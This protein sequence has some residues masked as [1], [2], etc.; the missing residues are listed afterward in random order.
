M[1]NPAYDDA[2]NDPDAKNHQAADSDA[3]GQ[4]AAS[5]AAISTYSTQDCI[6]S[7]AS[8]QCITQTVRRGA[9]RNSSTSIKASDDETRTTTADEL[10]GD[11][12]SRTA[13]IALAADPAAL[14][15]PLTTW[16][17]RAL[18]LLLPLYALLLALF[19]IRRRKRFYFVDHLVFSLSIHTFTFVASD[20]WRLAWRSCRRASLVAWTS[21]RDHRALHFHRDEALLRAGLAHRRRSNSSSSPASTRSSSCCPRWLACLALSFFGGSTWLKRFD[22]VVDRRRAGRL[23]LR[24]PRGAARPE[25]RDRRA[26]PAGRHL[27]QLGLHP[28]Q[29]AA[30]LVGD[31]APDAPAERVRLRA[32][33]FK[34][35]LAKIVERSR[36]VA[37]QLSNGVAFLMKK[38]KITVIAGE[39]KLAGQGQ[40][41][42]HEGRQDRRVSRPRTSCSPPARGRGRFPGWSRTAS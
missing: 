6:S 29:G 9:Q 33:N 22:V 31:L 17:P 34:F 7:R 4:G 2:S 38:H 11:A 13:S 25:D 15:G 21:V 19:H 42:R 36:K 30:A 3:E 16:M 35:D 1:T 14:N 28:D 32:D 27:P 26:R 8:A 10:D 24:D 41:R 23:C 5:R 18:F 39:A 37:Q 40:A 12:T 20:R